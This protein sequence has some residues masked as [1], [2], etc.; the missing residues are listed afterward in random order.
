MVE[1]VHNEMENS[2]WFPKQSEFWTVKIN[3]GK[4]HFQFFA[5]NKKIFV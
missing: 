1:L 3:F 2:D 4:L 5:L